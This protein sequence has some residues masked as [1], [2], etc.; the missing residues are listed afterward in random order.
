MTTTGLRDPPHRRDEQPIPD[1]EGGKPEAPSEAERALWLP[2]TLV[3]GTTAVA[4]AV[5]K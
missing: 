3:L 5:R 2:V 1:T 4:G